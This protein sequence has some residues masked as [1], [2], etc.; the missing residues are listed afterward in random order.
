MAS[1][2]PIP[3]NPSPVP[4]VTL[5]AQTNDL[6][7]RGFELQDMQSLD[8]LESWDGA[9]NDVLSVINDQ[10]LNT[11]LASP[12]LKRRIECLLE[13]YVSVLASLSEMQHTRSAQAADLRQQ[14]RL[15][16]G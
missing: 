11:G 16:S 6:I 8:D 10:V 14:R 4:E 9:V 1:L 5:M 7:V 15:I 13:L 3:D 2:Q 12:A